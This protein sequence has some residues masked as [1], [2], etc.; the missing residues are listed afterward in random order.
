LYPQYSGTTTASVFDDVTSQLGRRRWVPEFRFV[1]HY[2]DARGY[3]AAQAQNIRDFWDRE[4]RGDRLL[5]SFHGLP[6]ENLAKGDPYHC[7]CRKTARLVAEALDLD[8]ESWL[9]AF[10]SRVGRAEWLRPYAD[11][12][13]AELGVQGVERLDVVCPGFA[14]DCLETL[15]EIAMQNAERFVASGGGTLRYIPALNAREDHVAFLAGL[16]EKHAAGWPESSPDWSAND[17]A[18]ERDKSRARAL[19]MGADR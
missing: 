12:T 16:I 1:N 2:H 10:Q 18:R 3:V 8:G 7:Q 6:K 14:A 17:V 19:A 13:I 4:G 11:E 9:V 5:F 15:E